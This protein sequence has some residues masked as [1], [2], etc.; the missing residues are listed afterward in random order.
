M[1]FLFNSTNLFG[2]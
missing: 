1:V 2:I